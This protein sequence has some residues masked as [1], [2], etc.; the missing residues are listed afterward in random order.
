MGSRVGCHVSEVQCF[1]L[2]LCVTLCFGSIA[3]VV[4][5]DRPSLRQEKEAQAAD[6]CLAGA[7]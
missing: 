3:L 2:G 6:L 7:Y 4:V 5:E 1:A